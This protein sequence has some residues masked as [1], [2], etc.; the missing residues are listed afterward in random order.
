MA[1]VDAEIAAAHREE[2][3]IGAPPLGELLA[4]PSLVVQR[5]QSDAEVVVRVG[6]G[7][8]PS[9]LRYEAPGA[10]G[11]EHDPEVESAL[12]TLRRDAGR[13]ENAPISAP[14]RSGIGITGPQ[15]LRA[16]LGRSIVLQLAATLSPREW[17]IER[18][19][20]A[21][22]WMLT[23]PH[24]GI[25]GPSDAIR[26]TNVGQHT[27]LVLSTAPS[28]PPRELEHT[29]ELLP[30]GSARLGHDVFRPELVSREEATAAAEA[31]A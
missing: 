17:T 7:I 4:R 21:E 23:L 3:A 26:F 12:A 5:W 2:E 28:H 22:D 24:T 20:D 19:K 15:R 27:Q 25:D 31:L 16:S 18:P 8:R 30:G 10:T 1:R 13:L 6:T 29:V 9:T 11:T 14:L